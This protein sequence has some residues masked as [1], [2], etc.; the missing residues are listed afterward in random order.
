M[1]LDFIQSISLA[2]KADGPNDDRAGCANR[3]AW[4]I[5]GAT[6]L[7]EPGLLG[8][9]GGAAWIAGEADAAFASAAGR[10]ETLCG[11]VFAAV[12]AGYARDRTREPIAAW[13]RPRA[14]FAAV[15]IEGGMLAC[16]HAGDCVVLQA[17]EA[18]VRF[19]TPA[20][21]RSGERDRAA[22]LGAGAE[23]LAS[24][25]ALADR[26]A[27]RSGP[28]KCLGIDAGAT[29]AATEFRRVPLRAGDGLLLM[30]DGFSALIDDYGA[31][32]PTA[33]V[34]AVASRGLAALA[35]ELRGIERADAA[36][37]RFPRF[38]PSDDATAIWL[39]VG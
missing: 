24:E 39:R 25:A 7:G 10:L 26:R 11:E 17:S 5:D 14:S 29:L 34:A 37:A 19:V 27:S 9:R 12:A 13:E 21:D 15:A 20:P 30:S 23:A 32:D 6:D 18:G 36:C 33:L 3:H 2:G 8:D 31:Y 38:K 28:L 1:H 4:V 16:A 35:E 22:A